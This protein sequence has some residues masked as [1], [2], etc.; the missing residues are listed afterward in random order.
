MRKIEVTDCEAYFKMKKIK[1]NIKVQILDF[2]YV[3]SLSVALL[4]GS[5]P[6]Q[7]IHPVP[8]VLPFSTGHWKD[9]G[10]SGSRQGFA[11]NLRK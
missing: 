6:G 2:E 1:K 3:F 9:F 5:H 8:V 7:G 11:R 10:L 4:V